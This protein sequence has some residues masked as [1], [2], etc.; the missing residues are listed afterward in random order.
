MNLNI[1]FEKTA[2]ISFIINLISIFCLGYSDETLQ[3]ANIIFG[4]NMTFMLVSV[5]LHQNITINSLYFYFSCNFIWMLAS[6]LWSINSENAIEKMFTITQL[7]I[8][9]IVM[10]EFFKIRENAL[11]EIL[12]AIF[13]SGFVMSIYA[14]V[15]YSV[16]GVINSLLTGYRLGDEINQINVFG[17]YS[18]FASL[19]GFVEYFNKKK[20]FYIYASAFCSIIAISSG[21]VKALFILVMGFAYL[22]LSL[23]SKKNILKGIIVGT[24]IITI[25]TSFMS[26]LNYS[27]LNRVDGIINIFTGSGTEN[28]SALLRFYMINVG[29]DYFCDRPFLGYGLDNFRNLLLLNMGFMTYS[30]NNFLEILV[31]LGLVGFIN[32]YVLYFKLVK[33]FF[34]TKTNNITI[35]TIMMILIINLVLDFG[36]VSY[37]NKIT[38]VYLILYYLAA[39]QLKRGDNIVKNLYKT[40]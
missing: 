3:Y 15:Y 39:E 7:F 9:A 40:A 14:V 30:H 10:Y 12:F 32:Y 35:K 21:S 4:I 24:L 36:E 1:L 23:Y 28:T 19:I 17:M 6:I 34:S 20:A 37:Y 18:G 38:Y 16:N 8:F 33:R 26:Q 11:S 5:F 22:L 2:Y 29:W 27:V 13:I 25:A 31:D